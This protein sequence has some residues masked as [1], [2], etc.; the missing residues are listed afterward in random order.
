MSNRGLYRL[1]TE[2]GD[3]D[4]EDQIFS[5]KWLLLEYNTAVDEVCSGIIFCPILVKFTL[6][7]TISSNSF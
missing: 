7:I 2:G 3:E 1:R 5:L 4:D 6:H